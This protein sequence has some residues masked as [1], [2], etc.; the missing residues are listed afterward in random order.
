MI[1]V[2][3]FP[4]FVVC[5]LPLS[6]APTDPRQSGWPQTATRGPCR[7]GSRGRR[8]R[9]LRRPDVNLKYNDATRSKK[10]DRFTSNCL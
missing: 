9:Q 7:S 4:M 5:R 6:H 2:P 8:P 10:V 3:L 1:I